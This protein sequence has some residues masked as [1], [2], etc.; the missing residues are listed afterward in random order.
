MTQP[1]LFTPLTLRNLTIR[2]RVWVPPMCMYSALGK[3]GVPTDFH[4]AHY[5]AMALG[6]AGLIIVE[7]T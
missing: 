7:A 6:G 2:N 5:G 3:D 1:A 4:R